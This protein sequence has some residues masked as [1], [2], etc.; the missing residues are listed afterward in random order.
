[1]ATKPLSDHQTDTIGSYLAARLVELG[2][3]DYC[4]PRRFQPGVTGRASQ[5]PEIAARWVLQ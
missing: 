1:M 3:R 4:S 2:V 5:E